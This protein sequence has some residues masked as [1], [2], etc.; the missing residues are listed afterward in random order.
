MIWD[1]IHS[2]DRRRRHHDDS[3]EPSQLVWHRHCL[4]HLNFPA[5][6]RQESQNGNVVTVNNQSLDYNSQLTECTA[7]LINIIRIQYLET[8]AERTEVSVKLYAA[9]RG[10]RKTSNCLISSLWRLWSQTRSYEP[11]THLVYKIRSTTKLLDLSR[12]LCW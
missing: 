6:K 9:Q 12:F 7:N 4:S 3:W 10:K 1:L 2:M 5:W 8:I 11:S